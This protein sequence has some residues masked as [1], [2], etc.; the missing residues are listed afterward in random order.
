MNELCI[1]TGI[2]YYINH[3]A[4]WLHLYRLTVYCMFCEHSL[5]HPDDGRE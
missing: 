2:T 4:K 3:Y 5:S 1:I